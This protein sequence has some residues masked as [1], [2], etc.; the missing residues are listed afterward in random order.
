MTEHAAIYAEA[1]QRLSELVLA[2]DPERL[3]VAVPASPA[4]SSRDVVAHV[5]GIVADIQA[6]NLTGVG[7][8]PWTQAQVDARRGR[9]LA[10]VVEE[11]STTAPVLEGLMG[12]LPPRVGEGLIGDLACHEADVRG[13]LGEAPLRDAPSTEVALAVYL[14][15]L[16]KRISGAGLPSLRVC[17]GDT[18]TIAG[19]GEPGTSVRA[20]PFE[21]FRAVTGRRSAE[22]I[23]AFA[24]DGD[25]EPYIPVFSTYGLPSAPLTD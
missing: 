19:S 12:T 23:R 6:G 22:Q 5:T 4:W 21:L 11:W 8:E 9:S 2:A 15:R 16:G 3:A 14:A 25:P 1:R 20:D 17:A 7:T 10:E 13:A 18:E 24:W